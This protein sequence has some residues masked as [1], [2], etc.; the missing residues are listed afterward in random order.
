MCVFD[1]VLN[2]LVVYHNF[3]LP[4]GL[5]YTF[6]LL[7]QHLR[8]KPDLLVKKEKTPKKPSLKVKQCKV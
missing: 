7:L 4:I 6:K 1:I 3:P 5:V 8:F 2:H